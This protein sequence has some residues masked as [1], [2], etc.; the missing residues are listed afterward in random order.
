[1][2]AP[3]IDQYDSFV[4][5]CCPC[6][7]FW[8]SVRYNSQRSGS[9]GSGYGGYGGDGGRYGG[10]DSDGGG[11][12]G[13][14]NDSNGGGDAG[15]RDFGAK[16]NALWNGVFN[17][18][19][20]SDTGAGNGKSGFDFTGGRL[21]PGFH[22]GLH[23]DDEDDDHPHGEFCMKHHCLKCARAAEYKRRKEEAAAQQAELKAK[24]EIKRAGSMERL[25]KALR[26]AGM[27]VRTSF[28]R[29]SLTR[30]NSQ[31]EDSR[32]TRQE[33]DPQDE[34]P[35]PPPLHPED[36]KRKPKSSNNDSPR[37]SP[38]NGPRSKH[39]LDSPRAS[40][41]HS[42]KQSP[43][44]RQR[45][46][47]DPALEETSNAKPVIPST[48]FTRPSI[49]QG[50]GEFLSGTPQQIAPA[51]ALDLN[52]V[53]ETLPPLG[54]RGTKSPTSP[55]GVKSPKSPGNPSS[56]RK[57]KMDGALSPRGPASPRGRTGSNLSLEKSSTL[58]SKKNSKDQTS[59]PGSMYSADQSSVPDDGAQKSIL[60][61]KSNSLDR[62]GPPLSHPL[63]NN[64][65]L[66]GGEDFNVAELFATRKAPKA[67]QNKDVGQQSHISDVSTGIESSTVGGTSAKIPKTPK[68]QLSPRSPGGSRSPRSPRNQSVERLS[69]RNLG[70]GNSG[71]R[72]RLRSGSS[73]ASN[74]SLTS[75]V[76]M[77]NLQVATV[78]T[79][80]A[81]DV[82]LSVLGQKNLQAALNVLD[83][84]A[85]IP[86]SLSTKS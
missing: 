26:K 65:S 7:A 62:G 76:S 47:S 18:N 8:L 84:S 32:G 57:K 53:P 6:L 15:K 80:V 68:R 24:I 9:Y 79:D 63:G 67:S 52:A 74:S 13:Y 86:K 43:R 72:T 73:G 17:E 42:P 83:F 54:S 40:P 35:P 60:A 48:P 25:G 82:D 3:C 56:P 28:R 41:K 34:V 59:L 29:L 77:R 49:K 33:T 2:G 20:D 30:R 16:G 44:I 66:M 23:N 38:R 70:K 4:E 71:S 45:E 31:L 78:V 22:K 14:D 81:S 61:S 12:G 36:R 5:T 64:P 21:P 51:L 27:R 58:L 19:D 46:L 50:S 75:N 85:D 1:M 37:N 55:R 10:Y 11:Y 39:Q 69:P